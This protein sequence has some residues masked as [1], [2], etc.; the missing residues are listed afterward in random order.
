MPNL[1]QA[2]TYV[3]YSSGERALG[4]FQILAVYIDPTCS[5][6][7]KRPKFG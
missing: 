5:G 1:T 7:F 4:L 3:A 2:R 6:V